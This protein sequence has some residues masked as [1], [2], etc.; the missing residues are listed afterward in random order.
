MK[1]N[2]TK[3]QYLSLIELI[4]LGDFMVNG[5]RV[6]DEQVKEYDELKNYLFSYAK[7]MGY[8]N[9]I[10]PGTKK[11]E[12]YETREF[13]DGVAFKYIHD[14]DEEIFWTELASRLAFRDAGRLQKLAAEKM[15]RDS[16]LREG[17]SRE[18]VYHEEFEKNGLDNIHVNFHE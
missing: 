6:G 1:I 8:E 17:W 7:K 12:Y 18:N 14:Y 3:K 9:L 16:F 4:F 10:E 2:I 15:D 13:E 11:N 5:I